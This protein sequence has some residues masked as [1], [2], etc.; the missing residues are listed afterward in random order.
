MLY[1]YKILISVLLGQLPKKAM[2]L[3]MQGTNRLTLKS[4]DL[5]VEQPL[6]TGQNSVFGAH[7][8]EGLE[9][10]APLAEQTLGAMWQCGQRVRWSF[11]RTLH[12]QPGLLAPLS[13]VN[14]IEGTLLFLIHNVICVNSVK[15]SFLCLK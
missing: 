8:C 5:V 2:K 13:D 7:N 14:A 4:T 11:Q 10:K 12:E 1:G 15:F 6:A 3:S 9:T